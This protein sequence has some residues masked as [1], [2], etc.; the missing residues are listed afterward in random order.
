MTNNLFSEAA[1][2][3][4]RFEVNPSINTHFRTKQHK[5][6]T[7]NIP[8]CTWSP[9]K[10][11][12]SQ[13]SDRAVKM[14]HAHFECSM[15]AGYAHP[16]RIVQMQNQRDIR[17]GAPKCADQ[18]FSTFRCCPSH[19]IGQRYLSDNVPRLLRYRNTCFCRCER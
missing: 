4:Q 14:S 8:G 11:T 12:P 2:F 7:C 5:L 9:G 15:S 6:F 16:T 18:S 3:D 10:W 19:A 13:A 17:P 1:G